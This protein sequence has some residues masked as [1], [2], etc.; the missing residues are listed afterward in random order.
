MSP[1]HDN[2]PFHGPLCCGDVDMQEGRVLEGIVY[3]VAEC[4]S[5][6]IGP[7]FSFTS[8]FLPLLLVTCHVITSCDYL[9]DLLFCHVY[10]L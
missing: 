7:P 4:V 3:G 9:C 6:T 8:L 5:V 10:C 2:V 1:H